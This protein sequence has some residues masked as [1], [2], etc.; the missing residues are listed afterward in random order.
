MRVSYEWLKDMVDVPEDPKDLVN[1]YIRTGTEVEGVER[2][3]ADLDHVYTAQVVSK[4]P[5]PDSDHMWLCQVSVG[6]KNVDENG[7]PVPLQIVCGAQNFNEGDHIV[8]AM[9][10]A[11]LPGD[12]KI[13]KSKLRGVESYGMNCSE[14]ELGL[15]NDHDGII[16][17]P[18]DAPV[19]NN[20]SI[21]GTIQV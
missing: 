17:L 7:N 13:K 6:D 16:I 9:I 12:V 5:H 8:T 3:G 20:F 19:G 21:F 15:G 14:R 18:P 4:K 10:G 2:V 11:A 1:E